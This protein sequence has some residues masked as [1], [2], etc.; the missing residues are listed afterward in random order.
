M[1]VF[2]S[3]PLIAI[4]G[5]LASPD[6][7]I[8]LASL[9]CRLY[10]PAGVV[11]EIEREPQK[12]SLRG[13]IGNNKIIQLAPIA[14]FELQK[15]IDRH[16]QLGKGESEVILWGLRWQQEGKKCYCI[17]DERAARRIAEKLRLKCTGTIGLLEKLRQSKLIT[18]ERFTGCIK[19]L[20]AC[21]FRYNFKNLEN[22]TSN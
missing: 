21:G 7:I 18:N 1:K 22:N 20:Q 13:L 10:V 6:L 19:T 5:D 14:Q 11:A 16:P 15:F 4:L 9:G 2:D 8:C 17:I 12:S 3:S